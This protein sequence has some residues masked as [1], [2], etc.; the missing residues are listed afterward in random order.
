VFQFLFLQRLPVTLQT[1]LWEQE[2][3]DI[4]SLAA[5][6]DR[7]LATHKPQS[8]DLVAH[9]NTAEEHLAQTAAVLKKESVKKKKFAGKKL[10]GRPLA[11][12]G[13]QATASSGS[14]SC[15]G[16][17]THSEQVRVGSGLCYYTIIM[18]QR[19]ASVWPLSLDG[20]LETPGRL[21]TVT[22]GV[23]VH[24]M[25]QLTGWHFLLDMGAAFSII[26]HSS[27]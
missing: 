17:L 9:V 10:G 18:G 8:H 21:N 19:Q 26:P 12:G 13:G 16:V 24:V 1:L 4:R 5:G 14:G 3:G 2:P 6:A 25:D 15:S 7:L 20:K 22:P 23:L 27:S 11:A